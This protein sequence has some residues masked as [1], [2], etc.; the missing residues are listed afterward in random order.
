MNGGNL[1]NTG[2]T[3]GNY[4]VSPTGSTPVHGFLL[5]GSSLTAP[6]DFP[7]AFITQL[8]GSNDAGEVVGYYL[9]SS[10]NDT[11]QSFIRLPDGT[12]K[13]FAIPGAVGTRLY[14][15]NNSGDLAGAWYDANGNAHGFIYRGRVVSTIDFTGQ[16]TV[17]WV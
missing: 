11:S 8:G 5:Q 16:N 2:L 17:V 4:S 10:P 1:N 7:G 6:V 15:V 3:T 12:L 13:P 14:D 9:L